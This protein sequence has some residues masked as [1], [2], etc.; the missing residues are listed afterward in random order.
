MNNERIFQNCRNPVL[1]V[2]IHIT[3]GEAHVM[4]DGR[5]YVYGSWDQHEDTYCS[6]DYR[7]VSSADMRE[8]TDHGPS[9][10]SSQVPWL[11]DPNAPK[12]P[13]FEFSQPTPFMIQQA[14][15]AA[16]AAKEPPQPSP[17]PPPA[18]RYAPDGSAKGGAA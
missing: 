17:P 5:V 11:L 9:F 6:R 14:M 1:P 13:G 4:P 2:D 7:V 15:E 16:K 3:D 10:T 12:Y 18:R 8:W